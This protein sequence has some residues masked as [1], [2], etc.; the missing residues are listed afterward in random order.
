MAAERRIIERG[1]GVGNPMRW[2]FL[3]VQGLGSG[4]GSLAFSRRATAHPL[5]TRL[6]KMASASVA[7]TALRLDPRSG[8]PRPPNRRLDC[9]VWAAPAAVLEALLP[10]LTCAICA[11]LLD[12]PAGRRG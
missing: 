2:D 4:R 12:D 7:E 8:E 6:T 9:V 11:E 5:C 10:D 3:G 1:V